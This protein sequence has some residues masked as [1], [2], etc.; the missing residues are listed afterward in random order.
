MTLRLF[1]R[2]EQIEEVD[3]LIAASEQARR[4][5]PADARV[6]LVAARSIAVL[7]SIAADLR[8][9]APGAPSAALARLQ[10]RIDAAV[11]SKTALGYDA[12]RLVELANELVG[13]WPAVRQ[14]LEAS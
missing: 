12:I 7:K 1:T 4:L 10:R 13:L 11:A 9:S 8:G 14:A 6:D 3:A 2:E 5:H